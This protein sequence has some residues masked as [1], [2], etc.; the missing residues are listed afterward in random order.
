MYVGLHSIRVDIPSDIF[1]IF[2]D[3]WLEIISQNKSFA[4]GR[5]EKDAMLIIFAER[6]TDLL[7]PEHQPLCL[8]CVPSVPCDG[9]RPFS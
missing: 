2:F 5:R 7:S 3:L 8:G 1:Q 6:T 9:K 4:G